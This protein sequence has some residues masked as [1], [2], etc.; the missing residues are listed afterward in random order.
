ML[1]FDDLQPWD[2]KLTIVRNPIKWVQGRIPQA[3]ALQPEAIS[4]TQKEPLQEECQHF[5]DCCNTRT[6]PRT[7]G[8]EGLRVLQVLKAAQE[9]LESHGKIVK[10]STHSYFA[11]ATADIDPLAQIGKGTKIW[12]FSHIMNDA[13]IGEDCNIGQNVV[14]SP[15]VTLGNRVKIQNNVS[16]YSGVICEEDVFLGPGMVFTNVKNP[17]SHV[18]RRGEYAETY[19]RKGATIG[20][21]AT[22]ICGIEIGAY[23]FIGAGAVVTKNVKPYALMIG[24]PA[25]QQGW[26][27]RHGEKLNLPPHTESE[28]RLIGVCPAKG[29]EYLLQGETLKPLE[30]SLNVPIFSR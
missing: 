27:S 4:I 11:H 17:R 22:I 10:P 13:K 7:D 20:A 25:R 30:E 15:S 3:N 18:N 14:I 23:A 16:V 12:H 2:R 1:H 29:D 19:V 24:N 5:I 26:M 8:Y 28:E 9:S 6:A 21:N